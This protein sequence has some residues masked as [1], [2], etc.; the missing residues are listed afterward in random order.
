LPEEK[1][2]KGVGEKTVDTTEKVAVGTAKGVK[3]VGTGVVGVFKK[4]KDKDK[5]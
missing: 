5:E 2:E 1:K 4:D 3:K